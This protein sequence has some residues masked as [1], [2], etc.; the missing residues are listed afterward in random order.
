M[1]FIT[2]KDQGE[3][4]ILDFYSYYVHW[5][6][7]KWLKQAI[8]GNY[9]LYTGLGIL[10]NSKLGS[11]RTITSAGNNLRLRTTV[12]PY[13][14]AY[15]SWFMKGFCTEFQFG[16]LKLLPFYSQAS[17]SANLDSGKITSFNET[18][19]NYNPEKKHNVKEMIYGLFTGYETDRYSFNLGFLH[20]EFDHQFVDSLMSNS[21]S[22]CAFSFDLRNNI[23]PLTG[24]IVWSNN[25]FA[26]I[27]GLSHRTNNFRQQ[28]IF[29]KYEKYFPD[30]HGNAFAASSSFP[31]EEG[32]Y[33]GF[34]CTPF[35]TLK[36]SFYFDLWK[37]PETAFF[38]KMPTTGNEVML[39]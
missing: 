28:I 10:M 6:G 26:T 31:N 25:K 13:K 19:L 7:H 18:G 2:E 8:I 39:S 23:L 9:Q 27:I 29:R 3:R 24:E 30:W 22:S 4:N 1:G 37:I 38:E 32:I 16:R 14:S 35:K 20:Q 33:Y 17:L 11:S 34:T 36:L 21:I 5:Q 12:R 15:E